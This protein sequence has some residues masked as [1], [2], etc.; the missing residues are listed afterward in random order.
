MTTETA[1]PSPAESPPAADPATEPPPAAAPESTKDA[2]PKSF[3]EEIDDYFSPESEE[4]AEGEPA[5]APEQAR[6]D[7]GKFA[8]PEDKEAQEGEPSAESEAASDGTEAPP[9]SPSPLTYK[10]DGQEREAPALTSDNEDWYRQRLE[11]ADAH[12]QIVQRRVRDA[13]QAIAMQVGEQGY[14]LAPDPQDPVNRVLIVPKPGN[15]TAGEGQAK[16]ADPNAT[17]TARIAELKGF[18]ADSERGLTAAEAFEYAELLQAAPLRQVE[19][20]RAERKT[21]REQ[22]EAATQRQQQEALQQQFKVEVG[23]TILSRAKAFGEAANE[24]GHAAWAYAV[25]LAMQKPIAEV[26]QAV[27][28]HFDRLD[29]L[30]TPAAAPATPQNGNPP[31]APATPAKVVPPAPGA[32]SSPS[33]PGR[34]PLME[35]DLDDFTDDDYANWFARP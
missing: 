28:A 14:V 34:D 23:D 11:I 20:L 3:D 5:K 26:K 10:V 21:D 35:K 25:Q 15:A 33:E 8:K 2:P 9:A 17:E 1:P 31:P 19:A 18:A 24:I 16:P 13:V 29:A 22:R 4:A 6:D 32:G 7:D 30:R 12:P 27:L